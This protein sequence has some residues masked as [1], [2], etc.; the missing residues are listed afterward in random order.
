MLFFGWSKWSNSFRDD[1]Q[2]LEKSKSINPSLLIMLKSF[3][4]MASQNHSSHIKNFELQRDILSRTSSGQAEHSKS[5][6]PWSK[7]N[8]NVKTTILTA[9]SDGLMIP[10]QPSDGFIK[11]NY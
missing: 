7:L 8:D 11:S 6:N 5:S 4:V 3:S 1:L 10:Q 2:Q 9:A